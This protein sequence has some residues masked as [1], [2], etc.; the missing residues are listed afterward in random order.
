MS[1]PP[2]LTPLLDTLVSETTRLEEAS[3]SVSPSLETLI[4]RIKALKRSLRNVKNNLIKF[5][6]EDD[7]D[8]ETKENVEDVVIEAMERAEHILY[9]EDYTLDRLVV[10][11]LKNTDDEAF[12]DVN[13]FEDVIGILTSIDDEVQIPCGGDNSDDSPDKSAET[14][15]F[16]DDQLEDQN[17]SLGEKNIETRREDHTIEKTATE[18]ENG[19]IE[20]PLELG[21]QSCA[22]EEAE[23]HGQVG[24]FKIIEKPKE[25][26][27]NVKTDDDVKHRDK[28]TQFILRLWDPG[29]L[30]KESSHL[31]PVMLLSPPLPGTGQEPQHSNSNDDQAQ[32]SSTFL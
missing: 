8:K 20:N 7:A 27:L 15:S 9:P 2:S 32:D 25:I 14:L 31:S 24:I 10:S 18:K 23:M 1:L 28:G 6:V 19:E 17:D 29:G 3:V 26:C 4:K 5:M 11:L 16:A 13:N 12:V 21:L 22:M 30:S